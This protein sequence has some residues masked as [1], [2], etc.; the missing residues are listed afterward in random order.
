MEEGYGRSPQTT[1]NQVLPLAEIESHD[2]Q[3]AV[4]SESRVSALNI[5]NILKAVRAEPT[6]INC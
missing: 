4:E 6:P 2:D 5:A 3:I 1:Q